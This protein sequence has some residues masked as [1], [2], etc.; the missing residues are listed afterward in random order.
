MTNALWGLDTVTLAAGIRNGKFTARNVVTACLERIDATNPQLNA[1]TEVRPEAALEAADAAD[2]AVA[3]GQPLGLLHGIPVVIKACVDV[4]GWATDQGCAALQGN[5]AEQNSPCV[6]NWLNAGAIVLGRSNTPEFA[7]R[8]ET[9]NDLHGATHNPWDAER[10]PGG[11]SGGT[12]AALAVGMVPLGH[13]TDLGGSLRHPAQACG[14]AS[15]RP[16][17]GRVPGW[18]P[19]DPGE[20]PIGFQ[21][22]NTDGAMAR[23]VGDLQL[24]LQTMVANDLR[25]PWSLPVPLEQPGRSKPNVALVVNPANGGIS[26]Q[27]RSGVEHAGKLLAEAGYEVEEIEPPAITEAAALW[28]TICLGELLALLEPAVKDICGPT[29]Q[30]TFD[31]FR[32]ALPMPSLEQYASAFGRRRAILRDWLTFFER[33]PL[34]VAPVCTEPPLLQDEDIASP[35]RNREIIDTFR[36]TVPVNLLGLPAAVGPGGSRDG[37]PQVVQIIGPP[38]HEMHCL[39]AAG[40]IEQ[41]V[42]TLTPIDPR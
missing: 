8:W 33:Y 4:A 24:G 41:Q 19:T 21:L 15:I 36:M 37:F 28:M 13:G 29:L 9:T 22:M 1:L 20:P 17:R 30:R 11:S 6:Q 35:K 26:E 18:N 42:E 23:R 32:A 27:V 14:V 10:S 7:C 5:I 16:G 39:A 3:E 38:F 34:I 25:D 31:C 2:L 40:A 12:A